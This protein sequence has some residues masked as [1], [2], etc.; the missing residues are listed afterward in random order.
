MQ[1]RISLQITLDGVAQANGANNDEMDPG[2]TRGGWARGRP[3][4][5]AAQY[6]LDTWRR[7]EA[8]LLG[9]RTFRVFESYWGSRRDDGG[10]GTAIS[11]KPKFLVSTT[12]RESAWEGTTVIADDVERRVR[13]LKERP[14]GEL[15]LVGSVSLAR[16]LLERELVDELNLI[17]FPVIVGEGER[18]FPERGTDFGLD[19]LDAREFPTGV[20]AHTY[21]VNG[22]PTYA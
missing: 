5:E 11:A 17:R 21:R 4:A 6:I 7:P 8:F 2:F 20:V 9:R 15:L 13:E 1:L 12:V 14:G 22:R 3:D 18:V 16:W 19:L 10:F